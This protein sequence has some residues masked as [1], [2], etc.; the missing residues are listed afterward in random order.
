MFVLHNLLE[1]A[2]IQIH[3]SQWCYLT[4]SSSAPLLLLPSVFPSIRVFCIESA[5]PSGGQSIRASASASVLPM[6]IQDWFPLGLTG[7]MS[8]Q[9]KGLSVLW[10][11]AVFMVQLS[12]PYVTTG[13]TITLTIGHLSAK[14]YLCFLIMLSRFVIVFLQRSKHLLISWL[15]SPSVVILEPK[16]SKYVTASTFSPSICH[17]VMGL[18]AM[19]LVF[20]CLASSLPF[21]SSLSL[22]SRSSLGPLHFLAVEWYRLRIWGCWYFSQQF[23]LQLVIHPAW[24]STWCTLHIL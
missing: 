3:H 13:K 12:H 11:S 20:E 23:W 1:F 5:P 14:Y 6:N 18:D 19:I 21:Q 15:Q 9:S 7:L 10:P 17:E 16:K 2:Q 8:L 4:I 22:S 24:H